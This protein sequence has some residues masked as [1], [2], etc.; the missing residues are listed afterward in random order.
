MTDF[1][2]VNPANDVFHPEIYRRGIPYDTYARLRA[3]TPVSWHAEPELPGV[4]AGPGFWAVMRHDD[5]QYVSKTPDLFS[6]SL[7]CTQLRDPAPGDLGF[8]RSM[9]LNMDPPAHNPL[10]KT[11]S[12]LFTPRSITK[13]EPFIRQTTDRLVSQARERGDFDLVEDVTDLLALSTLAEILG[14]PKSDQRLFFDW[15]NRIIGYQDEE[16]TEGTDSDPR[17]PSSLRDMYDYADSLRA[18]RLRRP[19]DDVISTLVHAQ[20][21]GQPISDAEFKNFFFLLAVAGNDTTRSALPGGILTLLEHP[22]QFALLRSR[23]EL[24]APAVEECLRY[25]PPV[26]LFRR[27]ATRPTTLRGVEIQAGEKVVVFYPAANRDP[28]EF[29]EPDTFRITRSPNRHVSFGQGPHIC[30]AAALA[31]MQLRAMFTAV[32]EQLP[33][34]VQRGPAERLASNLVAGIKRVPVSA[35]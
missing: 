33:N 7:G 15:A 35:C 5:V 30:V 21:G 14:V 20:V 18:Y 13:L 25:A 34:L 17:S 26:I 10:R 29:A 16:Y 12:H 6:A 31:R 22:D 8:L 1:A 19:G 28:E 32:V 3:T 4:P 9:L 27:T 11:V 23:P 2:T 24:A